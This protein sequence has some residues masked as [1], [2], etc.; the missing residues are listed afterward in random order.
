MPRRAG[1]P[2]H[3]GEGSELVEPRLLHLSHGPPGQ[4]V[5]AAVILVILLVPCVAVLPG[6][7]ACGTSLTGFQLDLVGV[8]GFG[9][10]TFV[11]V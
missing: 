7:R 1:A 2:L 6:M 3:Q 11:L 10:L 5:A 9:T 4:H 8:G